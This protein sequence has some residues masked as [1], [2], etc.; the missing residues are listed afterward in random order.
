HSV[1][2]EIKR[3]IESK[4]DLF[5]KELTGI[6][7]AGGRGVRLMPHTLEKPK[8]LLEIGLTKQPLM[9]WSMLPML[10]GGVSHFVIGVRH[11][12]KEIKNKFGD[13]AELTQRMGR[14]IIIEYV[15]EPEP[16]GRAGYIKYGIEK[17]VIDPNRPAIIFNASDILRLNLRNLVRHYLWV[18]AYHGFD[19]V[20]VYASGFRVHYGVGK[21]DPSTSQ[22]VSF[23]EKPFYNDLANTAC[24]VIHGRLKDFLQVDKKPVNIEDI[25]IYKWVREKTLAAYIIP[26]ED[27]I[28]IKYEG[29]LN[30]VDEMDLE[31]FVG[32]AYLQPPTT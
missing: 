23:E 30:R 21:V 15:E 14:R 1:S 2:G 18:N 22:V 19:V 16:L 9:Y 32:S 25:L 3:V 6:V 27:L 10:L 26:H 13:G 7:S 8:P 5:I 12:A 29:D 17:G 11:G 28:S 31:R 4:V 24:Y 20:Q